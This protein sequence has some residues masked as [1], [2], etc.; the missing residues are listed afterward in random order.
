MSDWE[1]EDYSDD[2]HVNAMLNIAKSIADLAKATDGLLYGLKY[3]KGDGM[4]VAEAIEVAGKSVADAVRDVGIV[5]G[6]SI[7]DEV[8]S[9]ASEVERVADRLEG[10]DGESIGDTLSQIQKDHGPG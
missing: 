10:T 5:D 7:V 6:L 9:V 2:P 1:P 4:S 3:S 8:R